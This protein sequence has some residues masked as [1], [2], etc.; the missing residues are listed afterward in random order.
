MVAYLVVKKDDVID[1]ECPDSIDISSIYKY[2][3]V[4]QKNIE[5][6]KICSWILCIE[7]MRQI[8]ELE[9]MTFSI[10][11]LY[12][13]TRIKEE[14]PFL[15]IPVSSNSIISTLIENGV[16]E[17][18]FHMITEEAIENANSHREFVV[19]E[20]LEPCVETLRYI[21]GV[22]GRPVVCDILI[23]TKNFPSTIDETNFGRSSHCVL[24]VGYENDY[25]IFQNSYGDKWGNNGF[26][27]IHKSFI[28]SGYMDECYSIPTSC[29]K[30]DI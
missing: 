22:C 20:K 23:N 10:P 24:L 16:C 13:F 19:F 9:Y 7:Y 8:D 25:F 26:G 11:F 4:N 12:H 15:N 6:C 28:D 1:I 17:D 21:L 29:I 3:V 5:E 18:S 30:S 27:R 14:E 2:R